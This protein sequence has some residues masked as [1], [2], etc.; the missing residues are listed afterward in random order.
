MEVYLQTFINFKQNDWVRLLF[1]VKFAYN[2]T[3]NASSSHMPF[4]LNCDYHLWISYEQKVDPR[5]QSKLAD[6]LLVEL[7]EL[8]IDVNI[9]F[10]Q[11]FLMAKLYCSWCFVV[12][13]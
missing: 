7:R 1:M 5:S 8:M 9:S 6:E 10:Y 12:I 3:K 11:T 13:M 2:N 4:E